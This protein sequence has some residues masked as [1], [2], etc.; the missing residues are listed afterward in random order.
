M[1][2][3]FH[4]MAEVLKLESGLNDGRRITGDVFDMSRRVDHLAGRCDL[5]PSFTAASQV[6]RKHDGRSAIG[7]GELSMDG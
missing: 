3:A 1:P 7:H 6:K 4:W 2:A 5:Y